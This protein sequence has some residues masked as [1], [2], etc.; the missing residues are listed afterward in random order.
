EADGRV[1]AHDV[2]VNG[3]GDADDGD[4][5]RICD[6]AGSLERAVA[7]DAD[8]AVEVLV[9]NGVLHGLHAAFD[10]VRVAAVGAEHRA[11][12]D[13]DAG[14]VIAVQR[15]G[16]AVDDTAPAVAEAHDRAAVLRRA[17]LHDGT[18]RRVEARAVSAAGQD[19]DALTAPS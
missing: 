8:E 12:H 17:A 6:L 3:L 1:S 15:P 13:E 4:P 5:G 16:V 19:S 14:D 10:L 9:L 11:A 2:V 18:D 7:A